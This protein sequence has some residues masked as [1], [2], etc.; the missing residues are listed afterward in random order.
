M[1]Q[2]ERHASLGKTRPLRAGEATA[3]GFAAGCAAAVLCALTPP[4]DFTVG[5][6]TILFVSIGPVSGIAGYIWWLSRDPVR[7]ERLQRICTSI[8][9]PAI[10]AV[11]VAFP[12]R[13]WTLGR[14]MGPHMVI[15]LL[16]FIVSLAVF[17][18]GA[19]LGL[20]HL[21]GYVALSVR[22]SRKRASTP[23]TGGLWDR[24]LDEGRWP[25]H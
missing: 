24:D 11:L 22:Q 25:I 2:V 21:G 16:G 20:A 10:I 3:L 18:A 14:T 13:W 8:A 12:G 7:E 23:R 17:A 19:G 4:R 6:L 9:W 5:Y 1:S 15:V